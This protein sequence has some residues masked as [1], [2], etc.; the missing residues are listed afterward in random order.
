M[1]AFSGSAPDGADFA[2]RINSDECE[3]YIKKGAVACIKRG[4]EIRDGDV[5]LFFADGRMVFRQYCEDWAGNAYLFA[6]NRR[7]SELDRMYP[8]HSG[9]VCCF[10]LALGLGEIPLPER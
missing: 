2:L 5:G 3:P 10:G 6:L 8:A 4:A 1:S 9:A 7:R